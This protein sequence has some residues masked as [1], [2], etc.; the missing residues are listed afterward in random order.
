MNVLTIPGLA[1]R[2]AR[3][4]QEATKFI[5]RSSH[6]ILFS[7]SLYLPRQ[8]G[9]LDESYSNKYLQAT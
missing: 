7:D 2:N 4:R 6:C 9:E 3:K 1:S 8:F 5:D